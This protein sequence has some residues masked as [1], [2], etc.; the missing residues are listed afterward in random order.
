MASQKSWSAGVGAQAD[1]RDRDVKCQPKR[2]RAEGPEIRFPFWLKDRQPDR[3]GY[4]PDFAL[5]CSPTET[6]ETLLDNNPFSVKVVVKEI[7]YNCQLISYKLSDVAIPICFVFN[8]SCEGNQQTGLDYSEVYNFEECLNFIEDFMIKHG[9][10][11]G[12]MGFSQGGILSAAL[13]GMQSD[14]VAITKVPKIKYLIIM[15][16]GKLGGAGSKFWEADFFKESGIELLDAFVDP[17]VI[18]HQ[19]GHTIARLDEKGLMTMLSF[20]E[21]IEKM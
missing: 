12:L 15:S 5:T 1:N 9:P 4:G 19:K 18:H 17:L 14:G 11:D 21:K 2:C 7:N 6:K 10:F 3:C 8:D 16:G 13:P 20:I